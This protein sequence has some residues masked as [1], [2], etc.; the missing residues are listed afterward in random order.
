MAANSLSASIAGRGVTCARKDV[1]RYGYAAIALGLLT[2]AGLNAFSFVFAKEALQV[3]AVSPA[4]QA[5]ASG[6]EI[7][8]YRVLCILNSFSSRPRAIIKAA[9]SNAEGSSSKR[10]YPQAC[11]FSVTAFYLKAI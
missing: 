11:D 8:V 4:E 2:S 7:S 1:D 9:L 10:A 6:S 5:S 3:K